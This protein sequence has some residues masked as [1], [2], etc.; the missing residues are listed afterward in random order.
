MSKD[1]F[2]TPLPSREGL[3]DFGELPSGLSL[4]VED[5]RVE[6]RDAQTYQPATPS[7]SQPIAARLTPGGRGAVATVRFR[8]DCRLLD[9]GDP[10]LFVAANG[11][12][13]C[14][15]QTGRIVF[16]CWT[17]A[18]NEDVVLCRVDDETIDI[19][20][21]GGDA[22]SRRI[23]ADLES[24]G[25]AIATWQ[26][27]IDSPCPQ[28]DAEC[29]AA[30][31]RATTVRTAGILLEQQCGLLKSTVRRLLDEPRLDS[32]RE[33]LR[34]ADFGLHLSEPW[35]VVLAGRPNVGKSSLINALVGYSRSIVYHEPGTTRD[36]VTIETAFEGWP[37]RLIDTAG[38]R[39][40]ADPLEQAGIARARAQVA[41]ADCRLLLLDTSEPPRD[42][43][44][45]LLAEW[46]QALVVAHKCD[47][48]DA[49][50]E[51][52]PVTALKVSSLSR[53]GVEKLAEQ[54]VTRLI[55]EV[56]SP[57]T[58]VPIS[59]RQV[60]LLKTALLALE[61]QDIVAYRAALEQIY[62]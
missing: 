40:G 61:Q 31:V 35:N 56:P 38:I 46:P 62:C 32:L 30:L 44:R 41:N 43:D 3:G 2:K 42:E 48:R 10:P 50:G 27:M 51:N 49:W 59:A 8:G 47:L 1:S 52:L 19:H 58:A 4:R 14:D 25:C 39:E 13:V 45:Q 28:L 11:R 17:G 22:A 29:L 18:V 20:C 23:L 54:I 6:G 21:H 55:P 15:Q 24:R 26:Q 16:G 53:E 7:A 37:V 5:S 60:P 12:P 57:G 33:L 36:V 34:W 9:S